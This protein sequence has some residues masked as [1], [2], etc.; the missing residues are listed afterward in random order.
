MKILAKRR[1]VPY[2]SPLKVFPPSA[3]PASLNNRSRMSVY[4][5]DEFLEAQW[6]GS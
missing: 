3:S 1:D 2:K 6:F 5:Q 4:G